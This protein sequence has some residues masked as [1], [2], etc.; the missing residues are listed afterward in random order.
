MLWVLARART[1]EI[2]SPAHTWHCSAATSGS[3][4]TVTVGVADVLATTDQGFAPMRKWFTLRHPNGP[5]ANATETLDRVA[6]ALAN[7]SASPWM[8]VATT[9]ATCQLVQPAG[10]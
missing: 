10:E 3:T 1:R 6:P 8:T 5:A 2:C 9:S 7:L 4:V